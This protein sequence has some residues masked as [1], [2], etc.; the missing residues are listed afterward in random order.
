MFQKTNTAKQSSSLLRVWIQL[1]ELLIK[2]LIIMHPWSCRSP[3]VLLLA[4]WSLGLIIIGWWSE[5]ALS[6]NTHSCMQS[7]MLKKR[8]DETHCKYTQLNITFCILAQSYFFFYI[9]Y[10]NYC[11]YWKR[12]Q[13]RTTKMILMHGL[14]I[15]IQLKMHFNCNFLLFYACVC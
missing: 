1:L 11:L 6:E 2:Q 7:D 8:A 14:F 13:A 3:A 12:K 5:V 4:A 15:F 9:S 10:V